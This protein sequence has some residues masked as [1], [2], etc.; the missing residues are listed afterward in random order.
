[1]NR[2]KRKQSCGAR[3]SAA[4]GDHFKR[5]IEMKGKA[6]ER[7]EQISGGFYTGPRE[8]GKPHVVRR[9]AG[10]MITDR[11]SE[12][13]L[14]FTV[15]PGHSD[16]AQFGASECRGTIAGDA[17]HLSEDVLISAARA[18]QE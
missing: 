16:M 17:S 18:G 6:D 5:R 1:M 14:P 13:E 9:Q 10:S 2:L 7:H 12:I 3:I 11:Q 15:F 8:P 4:T